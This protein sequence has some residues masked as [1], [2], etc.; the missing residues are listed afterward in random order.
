MAYHGVRIVTGNA[1]SHAVIRIA[2]IKQSYIIVNN[3]PGQVTCS[4]GPMPHTH[5][6][7]WKR[8]DMEG[9]YEQ[10]YFTIMNVYKAVVSSSSIHVAALQQM[11]YY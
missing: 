4:L 10:L 2:H 5:N 6:H 3:K 1:V 7:W 8:R 11:H 9:M